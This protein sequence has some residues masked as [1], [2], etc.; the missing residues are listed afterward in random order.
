[1]WGECDIGTLNINDSELLPV[2]I[3][4]IT[5]ST[6]ITR[7]ELTSSNVQSSDRNIDIPHN[8]NDIAVLIDCSEVQS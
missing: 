4:K 8:Q 6:P 3:V 7:Q 5:R 2:K 1:M